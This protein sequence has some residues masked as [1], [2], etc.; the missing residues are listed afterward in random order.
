MTT[1]AKWVLACFLIV[2]ACLSAL[3]LGLGA[4]SAAAPARPASDSQGMEL[5]LDILRG[6]VP[7][8]F[9]REPAFAA[10]LLALATSQVGRGYVFGG[11]T[12]AGFD[13]SGFTSWA[14][15]KSGVELPRTSGQQF[16][17][18]KPVAV[19]GLRPGDLVF[20]GGSRVDHV[21]IYLS[22]GR[23]IHSSRSS[24]HVAVDDLSGSYWSRNFAGAR[25]V[26]SQEAIR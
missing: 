23:F 19:S 16:L 11:A 5:T 17:A 2:S 22:E 7:P 18:G 15:R 9:A 24:G 12:P 26:A 21:G 6:G 14:Y 3:G 10:R 13:C 8:W 1:G 20:F 4:R 25:R